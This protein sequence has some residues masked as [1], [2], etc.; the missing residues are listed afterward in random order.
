M[1][2]AVNYL[3]EA[4]SREVLL[5]WRPIRQTKIASTATA[6]TNETG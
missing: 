4:A 6:E 3:R 1:R 5:F 2:R